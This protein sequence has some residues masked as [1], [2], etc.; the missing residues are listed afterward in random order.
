M[1]K[2]KQ[3]WALL[4]FQMAINLLIILMPLIF[5]M[6]YIPYLTRSPGHAYNLAYLLSNQNIFFVGF[7]AIMLLAPEVM[8]SATTSCVW[9]TGTEFLLTR[10]VDRRLVFRARSLLVYLG[11]LAVPVAMF[12]FALKSP[13]LQLAEYNKISY[14]QVVNQLAGSIPAP[15]EKDGRSEKIT[16]PNGNTLVESWHIWQFLCVAVCTQVFV[17]LIYPLKYRRFILWGTYLG[18]IFVP[19]IIS[20]L[21]ISRILSISPHDVSRGESLSTN[22]AVFFA[23]VAHQWIFWFVT[24]LALLMGQL[25]CERRFARLE[26]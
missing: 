6:G 20:I 10:A 19:L 1:N 11:I 25:W 21:S 14:R 16:I 24:I 4:K 2:I 23:F 5:I 13:G 7:I 9:P 22:E 8:R 15:A 3:F 26:Q 12:L 18:C 17:L